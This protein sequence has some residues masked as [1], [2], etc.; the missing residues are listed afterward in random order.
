M[1][2]KFYITTPLYY[3]NAQPHIGH[4]YTNIASDCIARYKRLSGFDVF[5]LT[6]TDEHGQKVAQAAEA[7]DLSPEDF[8]NRI[9]PRFVK[10]WK[11]LSI[12]YDDFIR[13]T[14]VRHADTVREALKILFKKKEL[15][16][17]SYEGWYCTPCETFW[18]DTQLNGKLCPD[19]RRCAES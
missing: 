8:T 1:E 15:Y 7:A 2:R 18:S 17:G 10:L 5:F 4:S 6:G 11:K 16:L 12:S 19:C 3:V 9:V 14:E 13:T